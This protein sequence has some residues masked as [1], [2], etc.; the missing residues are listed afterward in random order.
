MKLNVKDDGTVI[1][2]TTKGQYAARS[3]VI[4]AGPWTSQI[5]EPL[6]LKLPLQVNF[7]STSAASLP[8]L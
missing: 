5:T 8:V 6:G 2:R 4:A 3:V 1:V 7:V